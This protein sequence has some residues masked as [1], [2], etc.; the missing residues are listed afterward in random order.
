MRIRYAT[1]EQVMDSLEI[2]QTAYSKRLIDAKIDAAS[3]SID[4]FLHRRF[5]PEKRTIKRDW[6]NYSY[7]P[8]WRLDLDDNEVATVS[9]V[10]AGGT[11]ITSFILLRR[12]DDKLEPPYSAIEVDLSTSGAFAAGVT[13]QQS[14]NITGVF[15]GDKDTDTTLSGGV[16]SGA[17]NSSVT[18]IV[19][20]PVSGYY[21]VGVGS[22]LLVDSERIVITDR[23]L[24][25]VS[26]QTTSGTIAA[27]QSANMI[28]VTSGAVFAESEVILIDSERMRVDDIAGNNLIV[29]RAWD[30]TPLASHSSGT[31]VYALRTFIVQRGV[32]G[33][34]AAAHSDGA[35]VYVHQYPGIINELCIAETVVFLEQNAGGYSRQ[36]G[37]GNAQRETAG[38]SIPSTKS[39]YVAG[40]ADIREKAFAAYGRK[41][42]S[43][44]I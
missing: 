43:A 34:S 32:L 19:I 17:I 23:R 29:S 41:L 2:T 36:I 6:P 25:A 40:I 39:L 42:R 5:Y 30:G 28:P 12:G 16:L 8:T 35:S 4:G 7:A 38:A 33:S 26:G 15:T 44:A 37:A 3:N 13:F 31:T 10:L 1:R 14:I 21:T 24:S 20:N 11:D 18:S 27:Q 22:L 9:Q